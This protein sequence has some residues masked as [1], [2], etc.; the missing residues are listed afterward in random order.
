[1]FPNCRHCNHF[2]AGVS[3]QHREVSS[4]DLAKTTTSYLHRAG[5]K[6]I[7]VL[8][9]FCHLLTPDHFQTRPASKGWRQLLNAQHEGDLQGGRQQGGGG[10]EGR[11]EQQPAAGDQPAEEPDGG[12]RECETDRDGLQ[13]SD[14]SRP[15]CEK[16]GG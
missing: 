13:F 9:Y 7:F 6:L 11:R 12:E 4:S 5:E 1:M 10:E 15:E 3:V 14:W 2:F 8:H 16:G